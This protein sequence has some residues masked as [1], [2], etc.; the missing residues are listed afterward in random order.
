M[1]NQ[2]AMYFGHALSN[3]P[4]HKEIEDRAIEW[5]CTID[6]AILEDFDWTFTRLHKIHENNEIFNLLFQ[7]VTNKSVQAP[8]VEVKYG[9]DNTS[10]VPTFLFSDNFLIDLKNMKRIEISYEMLDQIGLEIE[11]IYGFE[12][13]GSRILSHGQSWVLTK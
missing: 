4:R 11:S 9:K 2:I 1:N 5:G 7:I 13:L 8:I 6:F 10:E 12:Y 3:N